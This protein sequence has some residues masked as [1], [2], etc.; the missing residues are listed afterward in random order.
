MGIG[1]TSPLPQSGA[2]PLSYRHH[3]LTL[4]YHNKIHYFYKFANQTLRDALHWR[5]IN[6]GIISRLFDKKPYFALFSSVFRD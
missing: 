4:V 2:L 3:L 1:P 5:Y 6:A